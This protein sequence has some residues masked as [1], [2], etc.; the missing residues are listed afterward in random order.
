MLDAENGKK[1]AAAEQDT[2]NA[3]DFLNRCYDQEREKLL[4]M[5]SAGAAQS[6]I[7]EELEQAKLR[8]DREADKL[9][10]KI[11]SVGQMLGL[12]P[13]GWR[14]R[15]YSTAR[16]SSNGTP[17]FYYNAD[18]RV[19]TAPTGPLYIYLN[20]LDHLPGWLEGEAGPRLTVAS[21]FLGTSDGTMTPDEVRQFDS[22]IDRTPP[23]FAR[24]GR[25]ARRISFHDVSL[26]GQFVK[27]AHHTD[28]DEDAWLMCFATELSASVATRLSTPTALKRTAVEVVD[29][30]SLREAL[31]E[32]VGFSGF[33]GPVRYSV[34]PQRHH[35]LKGMSEADQLEYRLVWPAEPPVVP[36]PVWI[37]RGLVK[38]TGSK[39]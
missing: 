2:R 27:E 9:L 32:Q 22:N 6:L 19:R 8:Y 31:D 13:S 34:N 38:W 29:F 37:P 11:D 35:H 1:F 20:S 21:S 10:E 12:P 3:V 36:K 28:F 30:D 5:E 26:N 18:V 15:F 23:G 25:G 24:L 39:F 7:R 33:F 16:E 4:G 17:I 14:E